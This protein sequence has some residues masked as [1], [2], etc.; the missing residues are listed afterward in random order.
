LR[1]ETRNRI[2]LFSFVLTVFVIW[3]HAG[4]SLISSIPGQIAVPGFFILSGFLFYC[5]SGTVLH[6]PIGDGVSST[7]GDDGICSATGDDASA[8]GPKKTCGF[9]PAWMGK[10]LLRRIR[11]LLIPYLVWNA[12]YFVIYL[13]A[14]K[15]SISEFP[16][17]V[18]F[19]SCNPVFW[20]LFQLNLITAMTPL[21]YLIM[22]RKVTAIIWLALIFVM[23]VFYGT[24]HTW[25]PASFINEDALFYYSVGAFLALYVAKPQRAESQRAESQ[26]AESQSA[27]SQP[28][29]SRKLIGIS[30]GASAGLMLLFTAMRYLLPGELLNIGVI[31]QRLSG[32]LLVWFIVGLPKKIRIFPWMK[33]T[34]FIYATH[35]MVIRAVW[36]GE[37]ALGLNGNEPANMITYF[38]MPAICVA[39]AYGLYILMKKLMPKTLAFLTGGRGD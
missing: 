35:Y 6:R 22:K 2:I 28:M 10:K 12:I 20:Y 11:T 17:A 38:L 33:I 30:A 7:P 25:I 24:I 29:E 8:D 21:L 34:F 26:R 39:A 1:E 9:F 18:L 16:Q 27:E 5:G 3:L 31:G 4:E 19:Y 37:T 15:A 36:A 23:A 13:I 32:A 14:G